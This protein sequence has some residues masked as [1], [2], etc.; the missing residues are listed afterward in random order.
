MVF[1]WQRLCRQDLFQVCRQGDKLPPTLDSHTPPGCDSGARQG[2]GVCPEVPRPCRE[3][4]GFVVCKLEGTA[5][6]SPHLY[7]PPEEEVAQ[8]HSAWSSGQ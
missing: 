4:A 2:W 1:Q 5:V 8:P 7:K 6:L 3:A